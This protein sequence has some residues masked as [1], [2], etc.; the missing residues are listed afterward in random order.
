MVK[1]Y[2]SLLFFLV[3]FII[4]L[5][6]SFFFPKDGIA[7]GN[8][9]L[10]F[11]TYDQLTTKDTI[12]YA[13]IS[14]ILANSEMIT[15]SALIAA[16]DSL[17]KTE[18]GEEEIGFDTIRADA[19]KLVASVQKLEFPDRDKTVLYPVFE[20][21]DNL[22]NNP[23][24]IRIMHYGDSQ[25]EGDRITSVIRNK[26]QNKFGGGGVGL[27][28]VLQPYEHSFSIEQENSDN[29]YRYT[30]YGKRDTTLPH[31]YYGVMGSFC[32]FT[33]VY[34]TASFSGENF[35]AWA[36]YYSTNRAYSNTQNFSQISI[37][38]SHNT[39]PF[40]MEVKLNGQTQDADFYPSSETV[41][42]ARFTFRENL[43]EIEINFMGEDSP[44]FYGVSLDKPTGVAVDNIALRGSSGLFFTKSD[45]QVM[46]DMFN[47]LNVKLIILEFGG[48][49]V[50][51]IGNNYGW[52][53]RLFAKQIRTIRKALP[54]VP[55]IVI[56]LAD[57]S[58]KQG[59]KYVT[60]E[61][62]EGIRDA[63]RD[64]TLS[65]GGVYWDMYEAMGG[66]N[67]MPSWVFAQPALAAS[68]FVHFTSRGA[69]IMGQMFYNAFIYEYNLYSK[70][71]ESN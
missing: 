18:N 55:I 6:I 23:E 44:N 30:L 60:Y 68:D 63:L 32:R 4:L 5:D 69:R 24:L 43:K 52:Y 11:Y 38:Y 1:P 3:V 26:I 50:P 41:Q 59:N 62:L 47:M 29:W 10:K 25:I 16:S 42:R 17:A 21:L 27:I 61:N 9:N 19:K 36:N 12:E 20:S 40:L 35:E 8:L 64:A 67:S 54:D 48:N 45:Y 28:P 7:I 57:M 56:G 51:Y 58:K 39:E 65:E 22:Q 13:D 37:Y 15:D 70:Q 33:P 49:V 14:S 66:K 31:S 71:K 34:D 2:K 53:G 46:K